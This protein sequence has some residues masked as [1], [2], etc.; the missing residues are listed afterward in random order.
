[1]DLSYILSSVFS[2]TTAFF[3]VF[4]V[5]GLIGYLIINRFKVA[6]I[7]RFQLIV[8][9]LGGLSALLITINLYINIKSNE[10]IERNRLSYNTL[11]NIQ[12]NYLDPQKELL[13]K[14]PEGYFLYAEMTPDIDFSANAPKTFDESK[15]KQLEVY[16]ALRIFQSMEDFLSTSA[17]DITGNY[18]WINNFIMWMQSSLLQHYWN[19]LS[20]N[21]AEDTREMVGRIITQADYLR[22]A[23]KQKG[24]LT[25]S[26]YDEIS[27][28]FVVYAR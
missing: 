7:K 25:N 21:Y 5:I 27:K 3:V 26:D 11:T 10:R 9:Y 17:Y 15:R 23:R 2:S 28:K 24:K 4:I 1:M 13:D 22:E 19:E 12:R 18:V 16:M 14:F 6:P 20:F 8:S